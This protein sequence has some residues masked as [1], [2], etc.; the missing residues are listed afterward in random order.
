MKRSSLNRISH[1]RLETILDIDYEEEKKVSLGMDGL[2]TSGETEI[3]ISLIDEEI[4]GVK[5]IILQDKAL[6]FSRQTEPLE[7]LMVNLVNTFS[8]K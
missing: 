2:K 6:I 5:R 4:E 8:K 3:G 1:P 7:D